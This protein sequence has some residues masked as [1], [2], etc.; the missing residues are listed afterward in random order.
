MNEVVDEWYAK[1]ID[2]DQDFI[3]DLILASKRL[4]IQP[5]FELACAA[6]SSILN[7]KKNILKSEK[8]LLVELPVAIPIAVE[9]EEYNDYN[10]GNEKVEIEA[11]EV[12]EVDEKVEIEGNI[13]I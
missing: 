9:A 12:C 7:R 8:A 3:F 2:I 13:E 11:V 10:N 6:M 5:L 1:F 4:E